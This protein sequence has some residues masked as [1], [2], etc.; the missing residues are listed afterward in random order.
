MIGLLGTRPV[1]PR[2]SDGARD[3]ESTMTA[4][5]GFFGPQPY[6]GAVL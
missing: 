6:Q 5:G 2:S 4:I 1:I 3:E